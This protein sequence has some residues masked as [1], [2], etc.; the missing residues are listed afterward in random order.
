MLSGSGQ[1]RKP[2]SSAS[3]AASSS[4]VSSKSK[5]SKF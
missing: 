5:T 4:L 3:M 2:V 1:P